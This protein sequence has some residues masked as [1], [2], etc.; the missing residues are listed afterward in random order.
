MKNIPSRLAGS[1][2]VLCDTKQRE[3]G[4]RNL[5]RKDLN[6]NNCLEKKAPDSQIVD[7][8]FVGDFVEQN[9]ISSADLF[10]IH[11]GEQH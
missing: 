9:E 11:H 4:N 7:E 6:W 3:N 10:M 5:K 2:W 1:R 8:A